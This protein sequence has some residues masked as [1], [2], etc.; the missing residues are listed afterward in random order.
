MVR[1]YGFQILRLFHQAL[2]EKQA[3]R[4]LINLD[5]LCPRSLKVKY[6]PRG[7]VFDTNFQKSKSPSPQSIMYGT[8]FLKSG[9]IWRVYMGRVLIPG[10]TILYWE[11]AYRWAEINGGQGQ[12][13]A[14]AFL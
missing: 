12:G 6:Y 7:H 8:K 11:K 3:W 10:E 4:L 2:L 13:P 14:T 5:S 9:A 1:G